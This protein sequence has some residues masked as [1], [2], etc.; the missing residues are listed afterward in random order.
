MYSE[1]GYRHLV[2]DNAA[3]SINRREK[4]SGLSHIINC[5]EKRKENKYLISENFSESGWKEHNGQ[6]VKPNLFQFDN[7]P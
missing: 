3:Q 7:L 5:K 2:N 6:L 1:T 4:N